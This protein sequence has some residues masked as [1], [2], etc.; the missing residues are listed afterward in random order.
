[1]NWITF[2]RTDDCSNRFSYSGNQLQTFVR[3][4]S[5]SFLVT[6]ELEAKSLNNSKQAHLIETSKLEISN[7]NND[8]D[9]IGDKMQY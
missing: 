8:E 5:R 1:M 2:K 3:T 6:G 7:L 9:Q 4:F